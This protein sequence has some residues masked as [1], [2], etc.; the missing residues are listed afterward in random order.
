MHIDFLIK[1]QTTLLPI[2]HSELCQNNVY[3]LG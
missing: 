1:S 3:I 2:G